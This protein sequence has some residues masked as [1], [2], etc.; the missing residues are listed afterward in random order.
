MYVNGFH[1]IKPTAENDACL[2]VLLTA[3]HEA[4]GVVLVVFFL[5]CHGM[6][7]IPYQDFSTMVA[8]EPFSSS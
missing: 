3:T 2:C 4:G 7:C 5:I 8:L 1:D 6:I